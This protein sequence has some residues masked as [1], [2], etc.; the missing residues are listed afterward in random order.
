MKTILFLAL[1]LICGSAVAQTNLIVFPELKSATGDVLMTNATYR[2]AVGEKLYF[3]NDSG[4]H[5][6]NAVSLDTN[7]L[8]RLGMSAAD[9][10]A[11]QKRINAQNQ[12]ALQTHEQFLQQQ[13]AA[14]QQAAIAQQEAASNA[15]A[16]TAN[17]QSG[18]GNG[19][20][21]KSK[22]NK[23]NLPQ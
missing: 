19:S 15:A 4:E 11:A 6:F 2:L 9:R 17:Q 3:E 1:A 13:A 21:H 12:A 14:E 23:Y 10:L 7:V 8:N 16:M 20:G 5:G 18:T 22:K